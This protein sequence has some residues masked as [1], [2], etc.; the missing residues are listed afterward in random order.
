MRAARAGIMGVWTQCFKPDPQ[1]RQDGA[2][3]SATSVVDATSTSKADGGADC[4]HD[5]TEKPVGA[6][7]KLSGGQSSALTVTTESD[8]SFPHSRAAADAQAGGAAPTSA[9]APAPDPLDSCLPPLSEASWGPSTL[10]LITGTHLRAG[11]WELRG[12]LMRDVV[13][14]GCVGRL[15]VGLA[16]VDDGA[17]TSGGF[18]TFPAL[19]DV[20]GVLNSR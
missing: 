4:S 11:G 13:A 20:V 17:T 15:V 9:N 10:P 5:R 7:V 18:D 14:A 8:S 16:L 12:A 1:Q 6:V 3:E 19:N 2:Y